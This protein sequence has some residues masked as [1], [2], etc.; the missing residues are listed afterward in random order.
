M[1]SEEKSTTQDVTMTAIARAEEAGAEMVV[2][3][4]EPEQMHGVHEHHHDEDKEFQTKT[5][6]RLLTAAGICMLAMIGEIVGGYLSGSLAILTDAAHLLSDLAG[7]LISLFAL[8]LA[9]RPASHNLTFGYHR[10]E[11]IGAMVSVL[12]IWIVTAVLVYEAVNRVITPETVNG[13]VMSI[14]AAAG[15]LANIVMLYVLGHSH[16]HGPGG[17]HGHSHGSPSASHDGGEP[18]GE[19]V[20][21]RGAQNLH[22]RNTNGNGSDRENHV[23]DDDAS[24]AES[25]HGHGHSHGN[26]KNARNADKNAHG[27]G[28]SHGVS[29]PGHK[30]RKNINLRSAYLHVVGDFIQS[31]GVLIAGIVIL[32]KPEWH[33]VDPLCTFLFSFLVMA[34][35]FNLTREAM[36][37]LMEGTPRGIDAAEVKASLEKIPGVLF[38]HDLHI[39]SLTIGKAALAVHLSVE[40][41]DRRH[42]LLQ[43]QHVLA[44]EWGIVHTTIQLESPEHDTHCVA[45]NEG[46]GC[47]KGHWRGKQ[48][49]MPLCDTV[50]KDFGESARDHQE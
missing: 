24:C 46:P 38:A 26:A 32:I 44:D 8:W 10:A 3:L 49:Q 22:R 13:K 31:I 9:Q 20:S 37:V 43:A 45:A 28:H 18:I 39:W 11:I 48:S 5:R 47:F 15:L 50:C 17:G 1:A 19:N 41:E 29:G 16:G 21:M 14:T 27:H 40:T 30:R 12:V 35:T 2:P 23:H 7:F 4:D 36:H 42:V 6:N 25:G 33:I 34:T